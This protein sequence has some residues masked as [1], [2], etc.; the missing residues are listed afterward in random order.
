MH[1]HNKACSNL[2]R[3]WDFLDSTERHTNWPNLLRTI[4][5]LHYVVV[6]FHWNTCLTVIISDYTLA[7]ENELNSSFRDISQTVIDNE[8]FNQPIVN[9]DKLFEKNGYE[10]LDDKNEFSFKNHDTLLHNDPDSHGHLVTKEAK[11]AYR[12]L[13]H[14]SVKNSHHD[15][16]NDFDASKIQNI[17]KNTKYKKKIVN[18]QNK[19]ILKDKNS[20]QNVIYVDKKLLQT[21]STFVNFFNSNIPVFSTKKSYNKLQATKT[22]SV[23][24]VSKRR[25]GTGFPSTNATMKNEDFSTKTTNTVRFSNSKKPVLKDKKKKSYK[26]IARV[27]AL[28][29][30]AM[31]YLSGPQNYTGDMPRKHGPTDHNSDNYMNNNNKNK[32]KNNNSYNNKL[33]KNNNKNNNNNN[34]NINKNKLNN[35]NS[36]RHEDHFYFYLQSFYRSSIKLRSTSLPSSSYSF[37]SSSSI[38]SLSS[39]RA[40]LIF[41]IVQL[42]MGLLLIAAILGHVSFIVTNVS[43]ARKDFQSNFF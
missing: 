24:N 15:N 3:F 29:K 8:D 42:V 20:L 37:H 7:N 31:E 41:A 32:Y 28:Q 5:L 16:S 33:N 40:N 25:D 14:N 19:E 2:R 34:Q 39:T 23:R 4:V 12:H 6:I 1:Q 30:G 35:K 13:H 36:K 21:A 9:T 43:A 18:S 26:N 11:N 22:S 27:K 17:R 38:S 10:E